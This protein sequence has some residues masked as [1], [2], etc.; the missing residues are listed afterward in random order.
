MFAFVALIVSAPNSTDKEQSGNGLEAIGQLQA[1]RFHS[2]SFGGRSNLYNET[3]PQVHHP[4]V[5]L[6]LLCGC[7]L[8]QIGIS[9]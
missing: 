2:W 9:I 5:L 7:Q 3:A 6:C 1:R 8:V 4:F